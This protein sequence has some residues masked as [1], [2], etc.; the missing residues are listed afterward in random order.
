MLKK[1]SR[2]LFLVTV[3]VAAVFVTACSSSKAGKEK[4]VSTDVPVRV[5]KAATSNIA[6]ELSYGADLMASTKIRLL[7]LLTDRIISFPWRE[8]EEVSKGDV[9]AVIKKD[10]IS[11]GLAQIDAQ[12]SGLDAQIANLKVE[13]DRIK[14][15]FAKGVATRQSV[16]QLE[17]QYSAMLAQKD[18]LTAGRRQMAVNAGHAVVKAPADGVLSAKMYEEGDTATP[19]LPLATLLVTDPIKVELNLVERDIARVVLGQEVDLRMDA[20]PDRVFKGTVA[21]I[22]PYVDAG[23]RTNTV[24]VM[25]PNP[26]TGDGSR[27]LKPGMFGMAT[28]VVERRENAVVVPESALLLDNKLIAVQKS[29][30]QLRKAFVVDSEGMARE[31]TVKLGARN[32]N[33]WEILDGIDAGETIVVRGQHGLVDGRKVKIVSESG[34]EVETGSAPAAE[35]AVE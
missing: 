4:S 21:R 13:L 2:V 29:G 10:A 7:A 28:I 20:Y 3:C 9:I 5:E 32:G 18:A 26:R 31:R 11:H 25:V 19:Q 16:D 27:L 12:V 17:T 8:G 22:F 33:G 1:H 6:V 23:T 24:E 35:G 30:E 15:L 14:G 34:P